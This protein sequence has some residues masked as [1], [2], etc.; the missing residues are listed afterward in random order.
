MSTSN[1]TTPFELTGIS[2]RPTTQ[3]AEF[4]GKT[5]IVDDKYGNFAADCDGSLLEGDSYN[6]LPHHTTVGSDE[7]SGHGH[8]HLAIAFTGP[9]TA[10]TY[11]IAGSYVDSN[12]S[13]Q[14]NRPYP[15]ST[16][17][18]QVS[19]FFPTP[20]TSERESANHN[21][22]PDGSVSSS[23]SHHSQHS[24]SP[25][26][27]QNNGSPTLEAWYNDNQRHESIAYR[28]AKPAA[29]PAMEK[30]SAKKSPKAR[31]HK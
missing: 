2:G 3:Y 8:G 12:T 22:Q 14:M 28:L 5:Y 25:F 27:T 29:G 4:Q 15:T 26:P 13:I 10:G 9:S 11:S 30:K 19:G 21:P 23:N 24:M 7:P 17:L 6:S 31:K 18:S 16:S 1:Q 20:S